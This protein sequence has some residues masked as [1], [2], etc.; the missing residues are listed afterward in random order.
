MYSTKAIKLSR[1]DTTLDL[2]QKAEKGMNRTAQA[3]APGAHHTDAGRGRVMGEHDGR[4][5][6]H[7]PTSCPCSL[8][9]S[10]EVVERG[11]KQVRWDTSKQTL[12]TC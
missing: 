7:R 3:R 5:L 4:P 8:I 6:S 2:S 10:G 1:T 12:G 9:Q 11:R